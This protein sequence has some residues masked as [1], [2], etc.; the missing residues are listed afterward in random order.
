M[1]VLERFTRFGTRLD[2]LADDVTIVAGSIRRIDG[3]LSGLG[4]TFDAF[5]NLSRRTNHRMDRLEDRPL[6]GT[7]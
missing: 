5:R 1:D 3:A 4:E 7:V 6:P 2:N